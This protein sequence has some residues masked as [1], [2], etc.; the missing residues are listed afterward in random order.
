MANSIALP[1]VNI[2][3]KKKKSKLSVIKRTPAFN[4]FYL[5]L[6]LLILSLEFFLRSYLLWSLM[7]SYYQF[8]LSKDFL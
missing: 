2:C 1:L 8:L 5:F 3:L 6:H 4:I 7:F